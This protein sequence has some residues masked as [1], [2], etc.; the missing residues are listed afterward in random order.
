LDV[1]PKYTAR[2]IMTDMNSCQATAREIKQAY[3]LRDRK[4]DNM[5]YKTFIHMSL[6]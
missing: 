4:M 5:P 3:K 1:L 2:K 6:G